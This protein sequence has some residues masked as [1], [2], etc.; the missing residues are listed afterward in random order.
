MRKTIR[1]FRPILEATFISIA[2]A[3]AALAVPA[4]IVYTAI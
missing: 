1:K 2:L 3:T 4:A